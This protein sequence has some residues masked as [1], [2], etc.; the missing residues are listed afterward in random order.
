MEGNGSDHRTALTPVFEESED[1]NSS[2][3]S[4]PIELPPQEDAWEDWDEDQRVALGRSHFRTLGDLEGSRDSDSS[5]SNDV[6]APTIMPSAAQFENQAQDSKRRAS[7]DLTPSP[8][9]SNSSPVSDTETVVTRGTT[10]HR[11]K[12]RSRLLVTACIAGVAVLAVGTVAIA[13]SSP[14]A[15]GSA[16]YT[17]LETMET[18]VSNMIPSGQSQRHEQILLPDYLAKVYYEMKRDWTPPDYENLFSRI[19]YPPSD[20]LPLYWY[21]PNS[22]GRAVTEIL[23]YCYVLTTAS[24]IA[25]GHQ[26]E[27][28]LLVKM[29][30]DNIGHFVN[31][32]TTSLEGL[33]RAKQLGLVESRLAQTM[34]TPYL[35]QAST[36]FQHKTTTGRVFAMLRNPV[37][38]EVARYHH[39]LTLPRYHPQYNQNIKRLHLNQYVESSFVQE[40][41][42]V[43]E[44]ANATH[45]HNDEI[46]E[47][48]LDT[49]KKVLERYILIGLFE[50]FE[51]SLDRFDH[52]FGWKKYDEFMTC[53]NNFLTSLE[54]RESS[55][56]PIP[57][58]PE[59]FEYKTLGERNWA[60]VALY[61]YARSLFKKQ[62]RLTAKYS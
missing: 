35:E 34:V 32:D 2:V 8:E 61:D 22:G 16:K 23:T 60:D 10:K 42:L 19:Q 28:T 40:N 53:R 26:S 33:Q 50:D 52:Y 29:A 11:N 21:V 38:R 41:L 54:F 57:L 44:L 55:Y 56:S 3:E 36:L 6:V 37:L 1:T 30:E 49:A 9:N 5:P 4:S 14:D 25:A 17:F 62:K 48:H 7:L 13:F 31:I 39:Q 51:E 45:V 18:K 59:S 24:A 47:L 46:N 20:I 43:K 12:K 27:P 15:L 58:S